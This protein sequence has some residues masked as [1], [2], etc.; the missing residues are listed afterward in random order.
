MTHPQEPSRTV[1]MEAEAN[2]LKYVQQNGF[3][4]LKP[5]AVRY[6]ANIDM[7]ILEP[8]N[9]PVC[10]EIRIAARRFLKENGSFSKSVIRFKPKGKVP[11]AE[12]GLSPGFQHLLYWSH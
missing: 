5:A 11:I 8:E 9:R 3:S 12:S 10:R 4:L 7:G 2:Y 6:L 1:K